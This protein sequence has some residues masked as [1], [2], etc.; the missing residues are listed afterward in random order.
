MTELIEEI[1]LSAGIENSSALRELVRLI[2]V[3]EATEEEL[4]QHS[5]TAC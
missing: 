1:L 4:V 3:H 2:A 5:I